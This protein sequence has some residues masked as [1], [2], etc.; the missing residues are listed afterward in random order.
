MIAGSEPRLRESLNSEGFSASKQPFQLS[1]EAR[2]NNFPM[3]VTDLIGRAAAARLL[4]D[5]VSLIASW[6][7]R[8]PATARHLKFRRD[9]VI[10]R[11]AQRFCCR[12]SAWPIVMT[13]SAVRRIRPLISAASARASTST[14]RGSEA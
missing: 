14:S 8:D 6:H 1:D 4:R 5:L 2:T 7:S 3:A 13:S 10:E 9:P 11:A 12:I